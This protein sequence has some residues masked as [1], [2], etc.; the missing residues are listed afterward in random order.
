[1]NQL[2]KIIGTMYATVWLAIQ[3]IATIRTFAMK[4]KIKLDGPKLSLLNRY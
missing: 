3:L 4:L 2:N 1:M